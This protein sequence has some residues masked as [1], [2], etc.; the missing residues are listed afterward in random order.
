MSLSILL[1]TVRVILNK[2]VVSIL[3]DVNKSLIFVTWF[4]GV[5][6]FVIFLVPIFF[7]KL[8][9]VRFLVDDD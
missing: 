8:V 9:F 2:V 6:R 3:S 1:F 4:C 5:V 7:A